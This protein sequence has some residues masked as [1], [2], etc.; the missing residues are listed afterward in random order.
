MTGKVWKWVGRRWLQA[1]RQRRRLVLLSS[2]G[3]VED[4][5]GS[6]GGGGQSR[7]VEDLS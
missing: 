4:G 7:N 3:A 6:G 2:R 1:G 5:V